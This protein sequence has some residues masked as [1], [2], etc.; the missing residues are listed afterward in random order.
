MEQADVDAMDQD[1]EVALSEAEMGEGEEE[2]GMDNDGYA[3]EEVEDEL[4]TVAAAGRSD[5]IWDDHAA[6]RSSSTSSSQQHVRSSRS[7][8][9]ASGSGSNRRSGTTSSNS[10]MTRMSR[11]GAHNQSMMVG[12]LGRAGAS[13]SSGAAAGPSSSTTRA[14]PLPTNDET[15][16]RPRIRPAGSRKR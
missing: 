1:L 12:P 11:A 16:T 3:E 4:P 13:S 7:P 9:Y 5:R 6:H 8:P 10:L 2:Y 15:P 14:R